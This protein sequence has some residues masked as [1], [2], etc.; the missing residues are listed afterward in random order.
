MGWDWYTCSV[1][2]GFP[3]TREHQPLMWWEVSFSG[4][5]V[6]F[7]VGL[8]L[9][10][11]GHRSWFDAPP[12]RSLLPT[13]PWSLSF[14]SRHPPSLVPGCQVSSSLCLSF[15][16]ST[17]S[18]CMLLPSIGLVPPIGQSSIYPIWK[19]HTCPH[20]WQRPL[21]WEPCCCQWW[22]RQSWLGA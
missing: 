16:H 22:G 3:Y 12:P 6:T 5:L 17:I 18:V 7:R 4:G 19:W 8:S 13:Y 10:K 9:H 2:D 21:S 11:R 20:A 15:C 1:Y 14:P